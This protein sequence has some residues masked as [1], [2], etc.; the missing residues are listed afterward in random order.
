MRDST[1][2]A[3]VRRTAI[4]TPARQADAKEEKKDIERPPALAKS[5]TASHIHRGTPSA[6]RVSY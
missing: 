6:M 4:L 1:S 5:R 2:A 3:T